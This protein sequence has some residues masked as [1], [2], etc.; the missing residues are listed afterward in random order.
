MSKPSTPL[1]KVCLFGSFV[2]ELIRASGPIDV[3]LIEN[4]RK[5]ELFPAAKKIFSSPKNSVTKLRDYWIAFL[6]I[7]FCTAVNFLFSSFFQIS[8]IS[9]LYLLG[10]VFIAA[11]GKRGPSILATLAL[12]YFFISPTF[13]FWINS[14]VDFIMLLMMFVA[15]QIISYLTVVD[16]EEAEAAQ[17]RERRIAVLYSLSQQLAKTRGIESLLQVALQSLAEIFDAQ[18]AIFL[19]DDQQRLDL[20]ASF[21]QETPISAKERSVAY[22]VFDLGQPAGLG[23]QTLTFSKAIYV[24]LRGT[25]DLRMGVLRIEPK[26]P[27]RFMLPEQLHLVEALASQI[28][29]AL[30]AVQLSL[31]ASKCLV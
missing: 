7:A 11:R 23:T 18:T 6:M 12:D 24:A 19:P 8:N 22:W 5:T 31:K 3:R 26:D 10:V 4:E 20:K 14:R 15:V 29:L 27:K 2:S 25:N 1:W 13:S 9:M 17:L 21:P 28:A 30:D 16:R